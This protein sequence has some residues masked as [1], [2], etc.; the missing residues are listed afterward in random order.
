MTEQMH[1]IQAIRYGGP[2]VLKLVQIDKPSP[3]PGEVL[4]RVR[5]AAINPLDWKIRSGIVREFLPVTPPITLGCDLAGVV[6]AVGEG[7][8]EFS[9]G[10]EVFGMPGI[11]GAFAEY[12]IVKPNGLALKPTTMSFEEAATI[13]IAGLSAW[14]ALFTEGELKPGQRVLIHGG[15]GGT[16]GV[17]VQIAHAAG[18]YVIATASAANL[19]YVRGLGADEVIDYANERFEERVRDLDLV[20]DTVGGET[21][22]R[23]WA[24]L[25]PD[26]ILVAFHG[27]PDQDSARAAN[28]RGRFVLGSPDKDGHDIRSLAEWFGE[29]KLK[30]VIE[31]V[32]PLQDAGLALAKSETGHARGKLVLTVAD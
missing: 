20:L 22:S 6:E 16:G 3:G 13:P 25:K 29:G 10:D 9:A 23:S 28:V 11:L 32:F 7:V 12:A 1:A 15:A 5:A 14:Q 8:N 19:D 21:Q 30:V 18:A 31:G 26:G 17:A 2:D 27:P 4:V 24:T